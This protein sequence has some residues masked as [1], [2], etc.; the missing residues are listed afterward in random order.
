MM[1]LLKIKK[2]QQQTP[3][4]CKIS[5][6][7]PSLF[8][9]QPRYIYLLRYSQWHTIRSRGTWAMVQKSTK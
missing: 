2:N 6:N 3:P 1:R 9:P 4:L 7:F 5:S 8:N